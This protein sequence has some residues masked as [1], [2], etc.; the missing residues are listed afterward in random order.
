MDVFCDK[1]PCYGTH[2]AT[3]IPK[4]VECDPG[5]IVRKLGNETVCLDCASA[6]S[7]LTG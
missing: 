6:V 5:S 4:T 3:C 7:V 2:N 1:C